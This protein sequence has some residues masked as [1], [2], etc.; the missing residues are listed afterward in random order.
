MKNNVEENQS[1][2][3]WDI[4]TSV[5]LKKY[6]KTQD[7]LPLKHIAKKYMEYSQEGNSSPIICWIY[8]TYNA[9]E[10]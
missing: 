10:T 4:S 6:E 2:S 5:I 3:K 9:K 1:N 8:D 7:L